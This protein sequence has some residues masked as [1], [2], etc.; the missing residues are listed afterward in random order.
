MRISRQEKYNI[1]MKKVFSLVFFCVFTAACAGNPPAWW[2]PGN[3]YG[4]ADGSVTVSPTPRTPTRTS[5]PVKEEE[6]DVVDESY[7]EITLTPL[8]DDE[9]END[10][11]AASSQSTSD[12]PL[13]SVLD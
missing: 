3:R 2:N 1:S 5:A 9:E 6:I 13:P 8:S 10:T 11:G 7:E 4:T 12:L